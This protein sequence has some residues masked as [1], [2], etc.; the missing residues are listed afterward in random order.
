MKNQS[1][2]RIVPCRL[3]PDSGGVLIPL[4]ETSAADMDIATSLGT[5]KEYIAEI[6]N[7]GTTLL[8]RN[9]IRNLTELPVPDPDTNAIYIPFSYPITP[10]QYSQSLPLSFTSPRASISYVL[11]ATITYTPLTPS[12]ASN[13]ETKLHAS[14]PV[15]LVPAWTDARIP[16]GEPREVRSTARMWGNMEPMVMLRPKTLDNV[17]EDGR[18]GRNAR[19]ARRVAR[20]VQER[21]Q[22]VSSASQSGGGEDRSSEPS[23]DGRLDQSTSC[24]SIA[25][26]H[27]P[28]EYTI[29]AHP[30]DDISTSSPTSSQDETTLVHFTELQRRHRRPS[31]VKSSMATS[32]SPTP[33]MDPPTYAFSTLNSR[34]DDDDDDLQTVRSSDE[35]STDEE[36]EDL[37]IHEASAGTLTRQPSALLVGPVS[38][39][40]TVSALTYPSTTPPASPSLPSP[41]PTLSNTT[42]QPTRQIR[43]HSSLLTFFSLP[44][45]QSTSNP[46]DP[47]PP[48]VQQLNNQRRNLTTRRSLSRL[49]TTLNR[50]RRSSAI[51]TSSDRPLNSPT[52]PT[53]T[54]PPTSPLLP[55][56]RIL[57]PQT[58]LGPSTTFPLLIRILS[59]PPTRQI[60]SITST[61]V[62]RITTSKT[63]SG[64][65]ETVHKKKLA[66]AVMRKDDLDEEGMGWEGRL[67]MKVPEKL[68]FGVGFE[69]PGLVLTHYVKVKLTLSSKTGLGKRET[70]VLGRVSV[71]MLRN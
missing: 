32:P 15:R 5:S 8:F 43:R 41:I 51:A 59:I 40:P 45:V 22:Q 56:F 31:R 1:A 25:P 36:V 12:Y 24:N 57:F 52:P 64:K 27:Q 16:D 20:V 26:Q 6:H 14:V 48:P 44:R 54:S 33:S 2:L 10:T 62:A 46:V 21:S 19:N 60:H 66:K 67:E 11:T 38:R 47:T 69:A 61:L 28:P 23:L 58:L 71:L 68:E 49:E 55:R 63:P 37:E 4:P 29:T 7:G 42:Q 18:Y 3:L 35:E 13:S 34:V 17:E 30:Q 70:F 50:L 39:S 53:T 65:S 9:L